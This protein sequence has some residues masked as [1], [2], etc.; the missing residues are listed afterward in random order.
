MAC[1]G[2]DDVPVRSINLRRLPGRSGFKRQYDNERDPVA[3]FERDARCAWQREREQSTGDVAGGRGSRLNYAERR[4]D[5]HAH[6][7]QRAR[8]SHGCVR[9]RPTRE[10]L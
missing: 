1:G 2:R 10:D 7:R 4:A 8:V 6:R 3:R 9:E 5:G